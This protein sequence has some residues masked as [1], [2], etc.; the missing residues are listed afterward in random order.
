M[1]KLMKLFKERLKAKSNLSKPEP[2]PEPE[3]D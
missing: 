2:E 3:K 1:K